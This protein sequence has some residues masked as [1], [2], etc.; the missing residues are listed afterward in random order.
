MA[1]SINLSDKQKAFLDY[2]IQFNGKNKPGIPSIQEI[3]EDLGYSTAT[4]REQMELAKNLGFISTQPRKGV[5]ILPYRFAPAASKSL[6]YAVNIDYSYFFQYAEIRSNL[7][8]AYFIDSVEKLDQNDLIGIQDLVDIAFEKLNGDPVRIPHEEH[9]QYHLSFYSK[10]ENVFLKGI[11]EAYWDVYEHI[12]L[13][14][15]ADLKYLK[16]VWAYHQRILELS[17]AGEFSQAYDTLGTHMD[18]IY[19]RE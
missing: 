16:N 2:I 12:G 13:N 6:Y 1:N 8:K 17:I 7:E 10:Q 11:L 14:L 4:L 3:S 18:F 5:E 19:E 15:Y 9:R